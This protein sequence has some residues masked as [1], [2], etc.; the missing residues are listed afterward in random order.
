MRGGDVRAQLG[1]QGVNVCRSEPAHQ[2]FYR[3]ACAHL[4]QTRAV[5]EPLLRGTV[6]RDRCANRNNQ[7]AQNDPLHG[8]AI[9]DR[10][11]DPPAIVLLVIPPVRRASDP[12]PAGNQQDPA[13]PAVYRDPARIARDQGAVRIGVQK[14]LGQ[15]R[16]EFHHLHQTDNRQHINRQSQPEH[17]P[18]AAVRRPEPGY[19]KTPDV[20]FP[21]RQVTALDA[22]E[23]VGVI[24]FALCHKGADRD[25]PFVNGALL[26][27]GRCQRAHA[28]VL[29][30]KPCNSVFLST[31]PTTCP[32][33]RINTGKSDVVLS[34]TSRSRS[35]SGRASGCCCASPRA[36]ACC[37]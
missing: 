36:H 26:C 15:K 34:S 28:F 13:G 29:P 19:Q 6:G 7:E 11:V 33:A 20:H 9:C 10:G 37:R 4:T 31:T 1:R 32:S 27:A 14:G 8:H 2:S 12:E 24:G 3:F 21:P 22:F 23:S 25:V 17:E 30:C 16:R 5:I 18:R 35:S